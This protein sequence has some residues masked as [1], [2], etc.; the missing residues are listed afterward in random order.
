MRRTDVKLTRLRIG[1]TRYTH[2]HLL[3]GETAPECPSCKESWSQQLD[4]KLI[5]VKPVIGSWPVMPMRRTDIKLTRLR[6]G[7]TRLTHRHLLFAE[8]VPECPSCN[9]SYTV[10]HILIDCPVFNNYRITFFNSSHLTLPDLVGEIPILRKAYRLCPTKALWPANLIIVLIVSLGTDTTQTSKP[11]RKK[12]PPKN[13]SNTIK[14][15]I[16]IKTAPHRPRKPA[17]TEYSTDEEDMIVYDEDEPEVNPK[18]Y[19]HW[20][21]IGGEQSVSL[22]LGCHDLGTVTHELLHAIGF[23]HEHNRSDRDDYITINWENIDVG[24]WDS[25]SSM[26]WLLHQ[27]VYNPGCLVAPGGAWMGSCIAE[28]GA[29]PRPLLV[30][31]SRASPA[32]LVLCNSKGILLLLSQKKFKISQNIDT[33][34]NASI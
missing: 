26:S 16:E 9:V 3:F 10:H 11:R 2:R 8:H 25:L 20:G 4:N 24:A 6:I 12:R 15:K 14:P 13:Q 33:T 1:H 32:K 19:A 22:G 34:Q 30:A 17:P 29:F 7:H 27:L 5:S 23:E 28:R 21:R 18:C 31:E